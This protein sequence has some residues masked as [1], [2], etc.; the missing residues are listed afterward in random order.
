MSPRTFSIPTAS[1]EGPLELLVELIE[2]RKLL[3]N[4]VSL[5]LVTDEYMKYVREFEEHPIGET[6]QFV[7]VA[8]T[9]LLIKSKSLLPIL[10]LSERKRV[11]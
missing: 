5:A 8:S 9:L 4:D 7:L 3:V 11:T 10:D 2:K 1:F 6:A